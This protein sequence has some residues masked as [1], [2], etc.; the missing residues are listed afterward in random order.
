GDYPAAVPVELQRLTF[1][2]VH[3]RPSF[4]CI[5]PRR[6]TRRT[7]RTRPPGLQARPSSVRGTLSEPGWANLPLLR[8]QQLAPGCKSARRRLPALGRR[9]LA[10]RSHLRRRVVACGFLHPDLD[11]PRQQ[12]LQGVPGVRLHRIQARD[13]YRAEHRLTA[14]LGALAVEI[15]AV[16]GV[17]AIEDR[18][19]RLPPCPG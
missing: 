12:R 8:A 4:R 17:P 11:A 16:T 14:G 2:V 5:T 3:H 15:R 13:G 1:D 9:V 18:P 6:T 7:P 10:R 19:D